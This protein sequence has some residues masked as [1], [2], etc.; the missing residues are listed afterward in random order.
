MEEREIKHAISVLG[1]A[2]QALIENNSFKL[3]E[4]SNQT[5]HSASLM[6]DA[7]S[8]TLAVIAYSLSKL[9]ERGDN[10]KIKQWGNFIRK[11]KSY[12]SL[13]IVALKENNF[14]A[15]SSYLEKI[16]KSITSISPDL[17]KYVQEVLRK[18]AINK[19]SKIYEHGISMGLTA[20]LLGISQW[21]L[22]EYT[23]QKSV[24]FAYYDSPQS[25]KE[26]AKIALEFFS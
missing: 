5:I 20:K 6:Q 4:L 8:I 18:A 15:Y 13:A 22:S 7:G 17:K 23:G 24:S 1:E 12:I 26:R 19:A 16:R 21:E 10:N 2:K 14:E 9:I 25:V 3:N 11:A